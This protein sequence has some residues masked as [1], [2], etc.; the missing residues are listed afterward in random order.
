M[1][2]AYLVALIVLPLAAS[3]CWGGDRGAPRSEEGGPASPGSVAGDRVA[4][5]SAASRNSTLAADSLAN[6]RIGGPYGTVL[7][8]RFRSGWTGVVRRVRFYVVLNSDGRAGYSGGTG[9]TVRVALVPDSG[10]RRHVPEGRRL[11][12]AT[13][14]PPSRDAWPLV[15]FR[16]A[17]HVVAGRYYHVTFTNLDPH[18][19]RNYVSVNALVS[20]GHRGP[21]PPV[22]DGL[23]VLLSDS[24]DGGRTPG[25]WYPRVQRRG[26]RYA[27]ILEVDGGRRAQRLGVGYME[28]WAGNPKPIGGGA[29]VRQLLAPAAGKAITGAWLRVR[30]RYGATAPLQLRISLVSGGVLASGSVAARDVTSDDPGWVHVRFPGAIP[31]ERAEQ[32]ALTATATADSAYEAFAIRKGTEFGFDPRTVF[33]GGFAQFT[34][35]GAWVGWDQWGGRDLRTGDLQFALDTVKR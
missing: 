12:S 26:D 34:Q 5:R 22:L 2:R 9:G 13:L 31:L 29:M 1:R 10:G 6:T 20:H 21:A 25:R 24:A 3:A 4:L 30:R 7:A 27:P 14:D 28:V 16:R 8:F 23:G 32:L 15:R 33:D 17:D 18:P 35:G 11:A 19:A